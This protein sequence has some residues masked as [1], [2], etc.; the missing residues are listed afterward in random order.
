MLRSVQWPDIFDMIL[1]L[2]Y[3]L[4]SLAILIAA[5][6]NTEVVEQRRARDKVDAWCSQV[7]AE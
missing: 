6:D 3:V 1:A 4:V 5:K 2:P 7:T